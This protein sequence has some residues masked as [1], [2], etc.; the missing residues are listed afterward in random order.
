MVYSLVGVKGGK[1]VGIGKGG[2]R[3]YKRKKKRKVRLKNVGKHRSLE[4]IEDEIKE[5]LDK[6]E[7][8]E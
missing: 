6:G 7:K 5:I 3:S 2:K 1:T 8:N 4:E